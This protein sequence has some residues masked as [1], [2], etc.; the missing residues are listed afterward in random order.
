M[1]GPMSEEQIE[2]AVS[3]WDKSEKKSYDETL[4]K[5]IAFSF[6]LFFMVSTVTCMF[7][8]VPVLFFE[9]SHFSPHMLIYGYVIQFS[10]L[11]GSQLAVLCR[12]GYSY[13]F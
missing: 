8:S 2:E 10:S 5:M 6:V 7:F 13:F 12:L 4:M 9:S 11:L 3:E 1:E